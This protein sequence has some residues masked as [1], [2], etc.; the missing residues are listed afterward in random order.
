MSLFSLFF[1]FLYLLFP[2]F[3]CLFSQRLDFG[4]CPK[5]HS[6]HLQRE[7]QE[8]RKS[9]DYGY[10]YDWERTLSR[11]AHDND[12]MISR[13]KQRVEDTQSKEVD[14]LSAETM[15]KIADAEKKMVEL[16]A[17]IDEL[18]A[19]LKVDEMKEK[20]DEKEALEKQ[21]KEWNDSIRNNEK[22]ST[23]GLQKLRV[24][25]VCGAQLSSY[26]VDERLADHFT[27]KMHVGMKE[28]RDTLEKLR[29]TKRET[30][31]YDT[32]KKTC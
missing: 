7:Y 17:Q 6:E 13:Q 5:I 18:T 31:R 29:A 22:T 3:L 15:A 32:R 16:D 21:I 1:L 8:A 2:F 28:I 23:G 27:G 25:E 26:E 24:C 20:N 9:K 4:K 14:L 19:E 11:I 30:S 12:L 10:E